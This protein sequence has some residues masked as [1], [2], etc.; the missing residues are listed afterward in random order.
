MGLDRSGNLILA[1]VPDVTLRQ[2]A[3]IA[4]AMGLMEAMNGDGGASSGLYYAGQ[5]L[6][7]PGRNLADALTVS[8]VAHRPE[9]PPTRA[10]DR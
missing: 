2:L 9:V 1:T 3:N 6:T 10:L 5:Y 8:W 4:H 7:T